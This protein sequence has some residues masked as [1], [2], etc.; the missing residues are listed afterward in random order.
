MGTSEAIFALYSL[1]QKSLKNKRRLYC[2]FVDY[3][4]AFDT[5]NRNYLWYK[6][7][8]IGVTGKLLNVLKSMYKN[9]RTAVSIDGLRSEYFSSHLGLMQ[10]EVLS[11][12]LFSYFVNDF[13]SEF[14]KSDCIPYDLRDLSLFLSCMRMTWSYFQNRSKVYKI[15]FILYVN[16]QK[17]GI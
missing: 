16:I 8:K 5:V 15:C 6:L 7:G 11:P 17:N 9:V 13:E 2:C 12:I 10:G 4:K 14:I 1:I 3:K